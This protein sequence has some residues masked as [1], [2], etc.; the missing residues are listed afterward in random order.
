MINRVVPYVS[1][2]LILIGAARAPA[3]NLVPAD[4][5]A[6]EETFIE[7]ELQ[8]QTAGI[9]LTLRP[10]SPGAVA[11]GVIGGAWVQQGPAPINEG[12]TEGPTLLPVSG[13]IHTV[14]AHP[15]NPNILWIGAVNGGIW[16]TTNALAASPTWTP[17]TDSMTSLSIGAL[18]LDP[19]D[20]TAN[21]LV[22][23]N[24]RN[25]SFGVNGPGTEVFRSTNGGTVWDTI[26]NSLLGA[27]NCTGIAARGATLLFAS[28]SPG[29][30]FR[31]VDSGAN[32]SKLEAAA[33]L[34]T[35][36]G[37]FDLVGSKVITSRLYCSV[38]NVGIYRSA[39]SGATWINISD[40]AQT[41][42]FNSFQ[43]NNTELATGVDGR[44]CAAIVTNGQLQYVGYTTDPDAATP[45]WIRMDLPTIPPVVAVSFLVSGATNATPIVVTTLSSHG[46]ST[47][48]FVQVK[49]VTGNL[50]ANG[51]YSVTV[52]GTTTF[53]LNF[54]SGSGPYTGGGTVTK[55]YSP[56]PSFKPGGQGG[57]HL[58]ITVDSSNPGIVY[59]GGDR[60][61]SPFPNYIGAANYSGNLWRGN[62]AVAPAGTS[63]SPQW[64]HMTHSSAIAAIPSGGT[65]S[66]T[67][68]HADSREMV[69]D[70]NGNLIETDD[71][72][73][74]RRTSPSTNTGD[75]SSIN[76]N[77]QVTEQHDVAYDTVSNVA[78]S[79]NQDTGTSLQL[80]PGGTVWT[81]MRTADGGDVAVDSV[82][83]AP[84]T[85]RYLSYQYLGAFIRMEYNSSNVLVSYG[86][87]ALTGSI[88]WGPDFVST[89]ELN[90][91]SPYRLVI[92]G[93]GILESPF[94]G[95]TVTFLDTGGYINP[96]CLAYG[97]NGVPDVLYAA[98]NNTILARLS[99]ASVPT[100]TASPY[101][102]QTPLD[103][104]IDPANQSRLYVAGSNSGVPSVYV[105]HDA[106]ASWTNLTGNLPDMSLLAIEYIP[107][108]VSYIA[109]GGHGGV[110]VMNVAVPGVWA[111][112][113]SGLPNAIVFDLDYDRADDVLLAGSLGRG[114]WKLSNVNPT[115]TFTVSSAA[116]NSSGGIGGPF[117]PAC[118][119][120][121]LQNSGGASV[122]WTASVDNFWAAPSPSSGMLAAGGST[123]VNVCTTSQAV[124]AAPGTMSDIITFTDTT[125]SVSVQRSA[126]L[127]VAPETLAFFDL[128]T[129]PGWTTQGQWQ[130]G[131]PLGLGSENHDPTSGFTGTN[132]YGYNLAGDYPDNMAPQNLT[133]SAL[134]FSG[135][136]KVELNFYR[137]LGV[138]DSIYDSAKVQVSNN[139]TV[140]TD[141][142]TNSGPAVS[143]AA[144]TLRSYDIS[145]VAANQPA[146]YVRWVMGASDVTVTYPGWNIDD[147]RFTGPTY[148]MLSTVW[149]DFAYTGTGNGTQ[150][151]PYNTLA[152][153]L[154]AVKPNGTINIKGD[155]LDTS[156]NESLTINR[157]VTIQ[158][159]NGPVTIGEP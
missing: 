30:L 117:A 89:V 57:I 105:T 80:T 110:F 152:E 111:R 46:L 65:A 84:N 116:L 2:L 35:S 51:V 135:S 131:V 28:R 97:A 88:G 76:G 7:N 158:A 98:M 145:S 45:A 43:S 100:P 159:V 62:T 112:L 124:Y 138:E 146:V 15:T 132:V 3:D 16:K 58:S 86:F 17:Y 44:L 128:N 13:A 1:L 72:G 103:L 33:G 19:T 156:S 29:G 10:R 34:P 48:D 74:Y 130:F 85:L 5:D 67:S 95:E 91:V 106:G 121:T 102:G 63:P 55:V 20:G 90:G 47:G 151:L 64:A 79:G 42:I 36:Y 14:V 87:P 4:D 9:N 147:V 82:S 54:S 52:L 56:N 61:Q 144:W 123:S 31:S 25:S 134:N 23:G 118:Q 37:V 40:A 139:G 127:T 154:V 142:W 50:A 107:G 96:D 83:A 73:I 94:V 41:A 126:V 18:E 155:S 21:T 120:F 32:W 119:A 129:N 114:A 27:E 69:L 149:T 77:L 150:A 66:G 108:S 93:Y 59:I 11:R 141:V 8:A 92:G 99:G 6:P 157:P 113:G 153:A 133:T 140:W 49:N 109:V 101:P 71:G 136:T 81:S 12:Q 26:S 70:A 39:D 104:V 68:P 22:A 53:R 125:N 137:W 78:F 143:D 75:W 60:Q 24:G 115:T 122:N 148:A 38:A